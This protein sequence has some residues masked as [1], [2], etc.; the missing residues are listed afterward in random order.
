MAPP[1]KL[2]TQDTGTRDWAVAFP[3]RTNSGAGL[4]AP[5]RSRVPTFTQAGSGAQTINIQ[6]YVCEP[7]FKLRSGDSE[8]PRWTSVFLGARNEYRGSTLHA[9]TIPR[10]YDATVRQ[11]LR[12]LDGDRSGASVPLVAGGHVTVD[13]QLGA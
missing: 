3:F 9:S 6:V 5:P 8:R 11:G 10:S 4:H 2:R 13:L 1:T 12:T 7:K